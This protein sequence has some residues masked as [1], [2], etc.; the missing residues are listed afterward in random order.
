MTKLQ[1]QAPRLILDEKMNKENTTPT[2]LFQTLD[3]QAFEEN[4][5]YRQGLLVYKA[6]NNGAP[7]YMKDMFNYI[8]QISTQ[9]RR[10]STENKLYLQKI[11]TKSIKYSGSRI[12]NAL[13]K[14]IRNAKSAKEFKDLYHRR[15]SKKKQ[16]NKQ[17]KQATH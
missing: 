9:T 2:V 14:E 11:H 17:T 13:N 4:V 8:H 16:T 6:L 1:K 5:K 12:W 3:W 7:G 10:P 15:S